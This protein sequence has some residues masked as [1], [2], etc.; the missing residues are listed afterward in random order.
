MVVSIPVFAVIYAYC[1]RAL[2][3][4]LAKRGFSTNTLDYKVDKYRTHKPRQ[5]RSKPVL[6]DDLIDGYVKDEITEMTDEEIKQAEDDGHTIMEA[7][8]VEFHDQE[9]K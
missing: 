8:L 9:Q 3:R 6:K 5:K 2:N 4:R 1:A 7:T